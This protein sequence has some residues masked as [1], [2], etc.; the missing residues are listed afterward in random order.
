MHESFVSMNNDVAFASDLSDAVSSVI[1]ISAS[2]SIGFVACPFSYSSR[3]CLASP[4]IYRRICEPIDNCLPVFPNT[5]SLSARSEKYALRGTATVRETMLVVPSP[6]PCSMGERHPQCC[7]VRKGAHRRSSWTWC[8]HV[9]AALGPSLRAIRGLRF[10]RYAFIFGSF[11][12]HSSSIIS[13]GIMESTGYSAAAD[14]FGTAESMHVVSSKGLTSVGSLPLDMGGTHRHQS[15]RALSHWPY[16]SPPSGGET[17]AHAE[18][19][20]LRSSK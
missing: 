19:L 8:M 5:T 20:S 1:C 10:F 15:L 9:D 14:R 11:A 6:S 4:C 17:T 16:I 2:D 3:S 7:K 18:R 13:D 12:T